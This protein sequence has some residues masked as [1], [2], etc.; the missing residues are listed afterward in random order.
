MKSV[1][2]LAVMSLMSSSVSAFVEP[3]QLQKKGSSNLPTIPRVPPN[4]PFIN[5]MSSSVRNPRLFNLQ[6]LKNSE[7][8]RPPNIDTRSLDIDTI[9]SSLDH[10]RAIIDSVK[11]T[12]RTVLGYKRLFSENQALS[13]LSKAVHL[14]QDIQKELEKAKMHKNFERAD[15]NIKKILENY[16]TKIGLNR[17]KIKEP[18]EVYDGTRVNMFGRL[19]L[20]EL[21]NSRG[22][23]TFA[24]NELSKESLEDERNFV[25]GTLRTASQVPS[26]ERHLTNRYGELLGLIKLKDIKNALQSIFL[27]SGSWK[28]SC[29]VLEIDGDILLA[30]CQD[31][32]GSQIQSAINIKGSQELINDEGYLKDNTF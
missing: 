3:A 22:K 25:R 1:N 21:M 27:P 30:K 19:S 9:D 29:E 7:T 31:S 11:K 8:S 23:G 17:I 16:E 6:S 10:C 5:G 14:L 26:M 28:D 15:T 18:A 24:F 20:D 12:R 4:S 32:E 13:P 2:T